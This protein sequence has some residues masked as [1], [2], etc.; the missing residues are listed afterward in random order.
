MHLSRYVRFILTMIVIGIC[1]LI[2]TQLGLPRFAPEAAV[3]EA[4][5]T[6]SRL[7]SN[8]SPVG[9][10]VSQERA[11]ATRPLRWVVS[12][13]QE[14]IDATNATFCS[15]VVSVLN[16]TNGSVTV[17]VEWTTDGGP[18][19]ALVTRQ[20]FAH[21]M[22]RFATDDE[23]NL[24]PFAPQSSANLKDMS[25]YAGVHSTEHRILASAALVCRARDV[26]WGQLPET[27]NSRDQRSRPLLRL[28]G[29][30]RDVIVV[31]YRCLHTMRPLVGS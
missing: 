18:S 31:C 13:V 4:S 8:V 22:Y 27:R 29:R 11:W 5:T 17:E 12:N 14:N 26:R 6:T 23:I 1:V 9:G 28:P 16:M 2:L 24:Q 20:I 7:G 25:G 15:T 10:A 30:S 21:Q 3:A 19:R